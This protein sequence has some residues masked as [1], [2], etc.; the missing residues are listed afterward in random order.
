[1]ITKKKKKW[2]MHINYVQHVGG[3]PLE[4]KNFSST[5]TLEVTCCTLPI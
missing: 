1:M 3:A 2:L 5:M 4:G